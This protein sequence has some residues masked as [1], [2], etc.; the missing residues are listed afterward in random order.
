MPSSDVPKW[1]HGL[2]RWWHEDF[3]RYLNILVFVEVLVITAIS[4]VPLFAIGAVAFVNDGQGG[5]FVGIFLKPIS[6]GQLYLYCFS[7]LATVLWLAIIAKSL[8][9]RVV[10]VPTVVLLVLFVALLLGVDPQLNSL[11]NVT[12][13]KLSYYL[14]AF[15]VLLYL[16]VLSIKNAEGPPVTQSIDRGVDT[17]AARI[18]EMEQRAK[19]AGD[20]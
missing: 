14:Y 15:S 16:L 12:I 7:T 1:Y 9:L 18:Q 19:D 17:L 13:I 6:N 8:L 3:K 5:D 2:A 11:R 4:L 10:I 20:A